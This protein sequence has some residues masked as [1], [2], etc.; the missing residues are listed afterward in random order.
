VDLLTRILG[1]DGAQRS[2]ATTARDLADPV[3]TL[4][5]AAGAYEDAVGVA[6]ETLAAIDAAADQVRPRLTETKAYPR[7]RA[8]LAIISLAGRE[9]ETALRT[10]AQFRELATADDV[11]AVLD[12]RVDTTGRHSG[13]TGPLPW[14]PGLPAPLAE[15]PQW[16]PYL[17]ARERAVT[18]TAAAVAAQAREFTPT[19][20]PLWARSLIGENPDLLA[21]LAVW[22]AGIGVA[23]ADRRPT[24]PDALRVAVRRYQKTLDAQVQRVLGDPHAAAQRWTPLANSIDQR[25]VS[26]P[27]WPVLAEHLSAADRAGIDIGRLAVTAAHDRP[28]PDEL[29][30]AALWW[31]LAQ[32][33]APSV[34][35]A[36]AVN[37]PHTLR[38]DWTPWPYGSW[39]TRRGRDWS[40]PSPTPPTPGGNPPRCWAPRTSCCW[41]PW[42]RAPCC[43]PRR[44]PLPWCP[45]C[46][47]SSPTPATTPPPPRRT[48]RP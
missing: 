45:G 39:P 42:T 12:W 19:S 6:A 1:Y 5:H 18:D 26:D 41:P 28:L 24:G 20:A 35:D 9:P 27:Y 15:H 22:R 29:P 2:A 37:A 4:A 3:G 10:A 25:L 8:H 7:L 11:A 38:P 36:A 40:P 21:G 46:K 23:E 32:H 16:G 31:R 33:L 14:L 13:K 43:A 47:P 17:S 34:L 30:G 48:T 44:W